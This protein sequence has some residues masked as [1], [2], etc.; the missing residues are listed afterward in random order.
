M[1]WRVTLFRLF[2]LPVRVD[3]SW[4]LLAGLITWTLGEVYFPVMEPALAP[5]TAWAMAVAGLAGLA[6]SIVLHEAAHALVARRHGI[7]IEG[8]TLFVFGGVAE[9]R[10]E[11][12]SAVGELRMALAGPLLSLVLCAGCYGIA[13]LALGGADT[14]AAAAAAAAVF[15]YLWLVN[16]ALALFNMLPAFPLDGGRVLRALLWR[17]SGDAAWATRRAAAGGLAIGLGL[18]AVGGW[19]VAEGFVLGGLWWMLIGVFLGAGARAAVRREDAGAPARRRPVWRVMRRLPPALPL[20][21][22]D[23]VPADTDTAAAAERMHR[24]GRRHLGVTRN[25]RCIGVVYLEDL[26]RL[27]ISPSGRGH[28]A[29]TRMMPREDRACNTASAPPPRRTGIG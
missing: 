25:G 15:E 3:A 17:W 11:P 29:A 14:W 28:I 12:S 27:E 18:V 6:T 24:L 21:A 22:D 5:A 8:I 7:V 9:M 13:A 4:L 10:A 1:P 19:S 16:L 2:G 20:L 23:C 26:A